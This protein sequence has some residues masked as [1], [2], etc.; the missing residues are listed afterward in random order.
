MIALYELALRG[1]TRSPARVFDRRITKLWSNRS[2]SLHRSPLTS[3][4]R[5]VVFKA[6]TVARI[7]KPIGLLARPMHQIVSF[8]AQMLIGL[9]PL[10]IFD[11]RPI[12][13]R[14]TSDATTLK[15]RG[16]DAFEKIPR[17]YTESKPSMGS[18]NHRVFASLTTGG[19]RM[20]CWSKVSSPG[21]GKLLTVQAQ[22]S[23]LSDAAD[24]YSERPSDSRTG[25]CYRRLGHGAVRDHL[26]VRHFCGGS[27]RKQHGSRAERNVGVICVLHTDP[28]GHLF[29][30]GNS[31]YSP[32]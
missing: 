11:E 16:R 19:D 10:V 15:R 6:S 32:Y 31:N 23:R 5:I 28:R 9:R 18:Y 21:H 27:A 17:I 8:C 26:A 29:G 13:R 25:Q 20:R 2:T 30:L 7:G 14:M 4:P 24:Q 12:A 1:M 3:Q 22:Q